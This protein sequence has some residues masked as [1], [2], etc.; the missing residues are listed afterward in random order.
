MTDQSIPNSLRLWFEWQRQKDGSYELD[1]SRVVKLLQPLMN[2]WFSNDRQETLSEVVP[3][4]KSTKE[5]IKLIHERE[6]E[7]LKMQEFLQPY[8]ERW[9]KFHQIQLRQDPPD[10]LWNAIGGS[11]NYERS[12]V[13]LYDRTSSIRA[14][15][16]GDPKDIVLKI[17]KQL[18]ELGTRKHTLWVSYVG[19]YVSLWFTSH[20]TSGFT[21]AIEHT[22]EGRFI[23]RKVEETK[24]PPMFL[25]EFK[26]PDLNL[27]NPFLTD[28]WE[29]VQ[30]LSRK[31]SEA[32]NPEFHHFMPPS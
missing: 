16:Y 18:S 23:A 20:L 12:P 3:W 11:A 2:P 27:D 28:A 13:R 4:P 5:Q 31:I 17:L 9:M 26:S 30:E 29:E 8:L 24:E 19:F 10:S 14:F 32:L 21:Y 25:I 7:W 22:G 1:L 6:Q 15:L